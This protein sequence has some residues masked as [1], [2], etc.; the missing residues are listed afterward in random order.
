[1]FVANEQPTELPAIMKLKSTKLESK[2]HKSIRI[3]TI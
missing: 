2:V 3:G 1:M